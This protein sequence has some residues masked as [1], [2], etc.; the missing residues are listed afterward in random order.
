[1]HVFISDPWHEPAKGQIDNVHMDMLMPRMGCTDPTRCTRD[2]TASVDDGS[3]RPNVRGQ[4]CLGH[5]MPAD[6]RQPGVTNFIAP[7][8]P[9]AR[10][11]LAPEMLHAIVSVPLDYAIEFE[12]TPDATSFVGPPPRDPT[13]EK[14]SLSPRISLVCR[15]LLNQVSMER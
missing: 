15:I 12:I 7:G 3:C 8:G 5:P 13:P 1:V 9:L 2:P 14:V 6:P 4:D 10:L 11:P